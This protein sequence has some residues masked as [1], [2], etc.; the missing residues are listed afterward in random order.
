MSLILLSALGGGALWHA[1]KSSHTAA[2]QSEKKRGGKQ[3]APRFM[4]S[5]TYGTTADIA[6]IIHQPGAIVSVTHDVDLQGVPF[7]WLH[8]INGGSY[9]HYGMVPAIN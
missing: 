5:G 6:H 8:M 4:S 7:V 3:V 9:K 1:A 2:V